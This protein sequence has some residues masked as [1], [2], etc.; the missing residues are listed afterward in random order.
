MTK[1]KLFTA[2]LFLS[3]ILVSCGGS[4]TYDL[5]T[6]ELEE[7]CDY[8]DAQIELTKR[9]ME[10]MEEND[11]VKKKDMSL[12]LINEG[13]V[14]ESKMETLLSDFQKSLMD[15]YD[16]EKDMEDALE[17]CDGYEELEDLNKE[18]KKLQKDLD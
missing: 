16:S 10:L 14:L 2:I 3:T 15:E 1:I 8:I 11:G 4:A 18:F 17:E 6:R 13:I 5:D 7:P 12:D 9:A